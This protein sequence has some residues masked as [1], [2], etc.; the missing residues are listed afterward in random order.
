MAEKYCN[1]C[2]H[3]FNSFGYARHRTMHYEERKCSERVDNGHC[4]HRRHKCSL[5]GAVRKQC[6]MKRL[7]DKTRFGSECW[8]CA[9]K[10][11]D[12]H[13]IWFFH[14]Y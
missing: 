1:I 10:L 13:N 6:F 2:A 7:N 8:S 9:D 4:Q 5:C 11:D 12:V 14:S 3:Y